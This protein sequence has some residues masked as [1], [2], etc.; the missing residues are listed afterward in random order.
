MRS[1][2]CLAFFAARSL[3]AKFVTATTFL[4]AAA[5]TGA[6]LLVA[7][8][9]GSQE[10]ASSSNSSSPVAAALSKSSAVPPPASTTATTTTPATRQSMAEKYPETPAGA[11]AFARAYWTAYDLA[12][13]KPEK[14][15][16]LKALANPGCASC[17]RLAAE[18]DGWIKQDARQI[19]PAAKVVRLRSESDTDPRV[20][21]ATVDQLPGDVVTA[22]GKVVDRITAKA[23]KMAMTLTWTGDGWKVARI[24]PFEGDV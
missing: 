5:L 21:L 13:Q 16:E 3:G 2:C 12:C 17:G 1:G 8:C 18:I 4:R 11:K 6:V 14:V 20:V 22:D 10:A 7:G 19:G 23:V 24:Q 15:S 9:G